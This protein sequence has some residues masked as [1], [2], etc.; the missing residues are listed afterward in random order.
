MIRFF[1]I[2][3]L[4]LSIPKETYISANSFLTL[5]V[6]KKSLCLQFVSGDPLTDILYIPSTKSLYSPTGLNNKFEELN[7][8]DLP[9]TKLYTLGEVVPG[10]LSLL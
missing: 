2:V 5:S 7:I 3:S 10:V 9:F 1:S 6:F 4:S 8:L